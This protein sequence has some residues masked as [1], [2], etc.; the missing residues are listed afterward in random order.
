MSAAKNESSTEGAPSTVGLAELRCAGYPD[1]DNLLHG[2][3]ANCRKRLIAEYISK[4]GGNAFVEW[5]DPSN[6]DPCPS[7]VVG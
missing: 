1:K 6:V 2:Q 5:I 4:K 7:R 3:C